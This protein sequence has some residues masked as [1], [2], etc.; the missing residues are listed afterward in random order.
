M[1][2]DGRKVC[3]NETDVRKRGLYFGETSGE[4]KCC[5][6]GEL[7]QRMLTPKSNHQIAITD[8]FTQNDSSY[9]EH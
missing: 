2:C 4:M 1:G 7:R 8:D 9:K 5:V 3:S 6:T